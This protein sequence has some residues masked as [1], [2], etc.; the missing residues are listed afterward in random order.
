[1]PTLFGLAA[2]RGISTLALLPRVRELISNPTVLSELL[3]L[4][5][6]LEPGALTQLVERARDRADNVL[7][8]AALSAARAARFEV[9]VEPVV[10]VLRQ[11][12]ESPIANVAMWHVLTRWSETTASLPPA[13]GA[14]LT[15]VFPT[16]LDADAAP[17]VRVVYELVSRALK[18]PADAGERW[19][20]TLRQRSSMT[21]ERLDLPAVRALLRPDELTALSA[22]HNL[23]VIVESP[24]LK[25]WSP[26]PAVY[27][28]RI[29]ESARIARAMGGS[30]HAVALD[31]PFNA[32][33]NMWQ[34]AWSVS[35]VLDHLRTVR[36]QVQQHEASIEV[37][38]IE[39][40]PTIDVQMLCSIVE[41]FSPAFL[42]LDIDYRAAR[43]RG[44]VKMLQA[45]LV[46]L[47]DCCR[48]LKVPFGVIIWGYEEHTAETFM[49]SARTLLAVVQQAV[50]R[51]DLSWPDRLIVQSWSATAVLG[52]RLIPPTLPPDGSASLW[53]LLRIVK[54]S[55]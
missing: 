5:T 54:R 53:G 4:A 35:H 37:G 31:E 16:E 42:H 19:M 8:D 43:Q 13:W 48:M 15:E 50:H 21:S 29:L 27:V 36:Q 2:G 28:D 3:Q 39:P 30:I 34:P 6:R 25:D 40:Y 23:R 9:P 7:L 12:V 33:L 51:G 17:D 24:G 55:L 46:R 44:S 49:R 22:A 41:T 26:D 52:P 20:A 14:A 1:V 11:S 10:G 38:L 47:A 45:D 32:G 18:R